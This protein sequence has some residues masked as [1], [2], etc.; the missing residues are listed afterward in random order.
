MRRKLSVC[1]VCLGLVLSGAN[2]YLS[3]QSP[4]VPVAVADG[5]DPAPPPA[6]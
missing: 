4:E 2:Y 1:F 6:Y 3:R 5:G